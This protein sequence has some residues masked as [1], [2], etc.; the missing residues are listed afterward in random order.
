VNIPAKPLEADEEESPGHLK[1][2][3]QKEVFVGELAE[4]GD[5]IVANVRTDGFWPVNAQKVAYRGH[6]FWI[7]SS[8]E[9]DY[10]GNGELHIMNAET[11]A[12]VGRKDAYIPLN[13]LFD[14]K[15]ADSAIARWKALAE[16]RRER[17]KRYGK[18]ME[19]NARGYDVTVMF[20]S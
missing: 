19:R 10:F 14:R 2:P 6:A 12:L 15:A 5:W 13:M 7:T 8:F 3:T 17:D 16:Q 11:G 4:S 1:I 9:H 20:A 18:E